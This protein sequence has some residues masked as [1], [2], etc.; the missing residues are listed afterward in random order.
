MTVWFEESTI[1]SLTRLNY[2]I[3]FCR[4]VFFLKKKLLPVVNFVRAG[5]FPIEI[6]IGVARLPCGAWFV[7]IFARGMSESEE[8]SKTASSYPSSA[9]SCYS[10]F[11]ARW[12]DMI[13]FP[14]SQRLKEI[15]VFHLL[16]A[17]RLK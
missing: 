3:R 12:S 1:A 2:G 15:G 4:L 8:E 13:D 7:L 17:V 16:L 14:W 5:L 9:P 10:Q 11:F 6:G